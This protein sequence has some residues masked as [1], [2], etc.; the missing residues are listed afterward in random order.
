MGNIQLK[1]TC[2]PNT[3]IQSLVHEVEYGNTFVIDKRGER[4]IPLPGGKQKWIKIDSESPS[5]FSLLVRDEFFDTDCFFEKIIS[6]FVFN[7]LDFGDIRLEDINIAQSELRFDQ[8]RNNLPEN[9]FSKYPVMGTILKPY[10]HLEIDEKLKMSS[11]FLSYGINLIKEDETYLVSKKQ[12]LSEARQIQSEMGDNAFYVP[13]VTPHIHDVDFI[14]E[15]AQNGT[16]IIMVNFLTTSFSP[17]KRLKLKLPDIIIWGHRVGYKAFQNILSMRSLGKLAVLS[18]INCL[19]LGT[20]IK[21]ELLA[22]QNNL[23]TD[24][25]H[26]NNDFLPIFTKTSSDIIPILL[27]QLGLK[28]IL[29][30]CGCFRSETTGQLKWEEVQNWVK[31]IYLKKEEYE[32]KTIQ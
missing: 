28:N 2:S 17:I 18:G 15:L 3:D 5:S 27:S 29:M 10:Y 26:I 14:E 24:L 20:T 13:N 16:R 8:A 12:I 1:Y 11:R 25:R 23:I 22:E 7:F 31:K 9:F 19:H 32:N 21:T 4:I 30:A 6:A